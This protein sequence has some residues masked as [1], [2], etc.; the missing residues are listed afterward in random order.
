MGSVQIRVAT[1]D[2]FVAMAVFDGLA[3]GNPWPEAELD[4]ARATV[5]LDRFRLA[6]DGDQLVGVSGAFGQEVTV[7][8]NTVVRAGGVTWVAVAPTHRRQGVL[9]LMM[10]SLHRD[11]DQR[12][13]PI[14]MLTASEGGI[15]ERFGYGIA[16]HLRIVQIDRRRTQ[17]RPELRPSPGAVRMTT[18]DDPELATL[19]DRYRR[20]RVGEINRTPEGD[21]L[22]R[23]GNP[24]GVAVA[25]HAD[26]FATWKVTA[27][28]HHG[29]PAH[30]LNLIDLV[31]ITPEAHVALWH[32]VLS[33]DL[34]GPIT[35]MR[36]VSLDDPLPYVVNDPRSIRT[37]DLND[38]LW[39]HLRRIGEALSAR[40]YGT[41]DELVLDV[42]IEEGDG[43]ATERWRV[44]GG[45]G[46]SEAKRVRRHADLTMDRASLG[47]IYL[48]GVRPSTLG[49]AGRIVA[50]NDDVLRR[51]DAFFAS[52][53]LPHCMT[54][55]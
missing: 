46:G 30:E 47:A 11:M 5:D 14:A 55:F 48:G 40:T 36:T 45:P 41:E 34:V 16:S 26:G 35:S 43:I 33:I 20:Q 13:E 39:L 10:E 18:L 38:M 51:A 42:A 3:F 49:R 52:D 37:T 24:T 29:H 1:D 22:F 31:A 53:R 17:I 6:F 21:A 27:R 54:G 9:T 50:R 4:A 28:W 44:A 15:Y 25:K 2:D 32:T 23:A 12:E 19:F 8:G 7:P